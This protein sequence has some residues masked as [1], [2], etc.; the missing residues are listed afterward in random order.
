M[1]ENY[2]IINEVGDM[3]DITSFIPL[4]EE[5]QKEIKGEKVAMKPVKK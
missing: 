3:G 2:G 5:E 1:S 4:T